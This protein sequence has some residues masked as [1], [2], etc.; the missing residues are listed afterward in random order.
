ME[1]R[2]PFR[3]AWYSSSDGG[4]QY[5][6]IGTDSP[7]VELRNLTSDR[8]VEVLISNI[9]ADVVTQPIKIRVVAS[10]L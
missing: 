4:Y 10:A 2:E 5:L 3:Y 6:P 8:M 9:C 1:G 7:A